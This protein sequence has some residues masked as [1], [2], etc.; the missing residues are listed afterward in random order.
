[1][2]DPGNFFAI[3]DD[4]SG[5]PPTSLLTAVS[6]AIN[7]KRAYGVRYQV[8]PPALVVTNVNMP[9]LTASGYVHGSVAEQVSA[10]ISQFLNTA[11]LD[12]MVVTISQLIQIARDTSP[13]VTDVPISTVL[14]NGANANL[15]LTPVERPIG[16]TVTVT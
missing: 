14:I 1:M 16:G 13:G 6:L 4:G 7:A 11:P 8:Y 10:A 3:I 15:V 9:I 12:M 5:T 2:F